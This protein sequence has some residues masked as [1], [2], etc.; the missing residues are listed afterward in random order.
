M[1]HATLQKINQLLSTQQ[2]TKAEAIRRARTNYTRAAMKKLN[3]E[4]ITENT[5]T[6]IKIRVPNPLTEGGHVQAL[7]TYTNNPY[8]DPGMYTQTQTRTTTKN[9]RKAS[10]LT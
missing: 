2:I 3:S 5:F 6:S 9:I 1:K 4:G 8:S 7:I 10:L